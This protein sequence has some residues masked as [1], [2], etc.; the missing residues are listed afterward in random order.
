MS[1]RSKPRC[2]Q[3][4]TRRTWAW[5]ASIAARYCTRGGGAA[6]LRER[7]GEGLDIAFLDRGPDLR[8]PGLEGAGGRAHR[9]PSRSRARRRSRR[10][11]RDAPPR[12][13]AR[14]LRAAWPPPTPQR[15]SPGASATSRGAR[16]MAPIAQAPGRGAHLARERARAA[17]PP[18]RD[19]PR[20]RRS[21]GRA[22]PR[23]RAPSASRS[24]PRSSRPSARRPRSERR[25]PA[26][27]LEPHQAAVAGRNPDRPA[28]VAGVRRRHQPGR[29]R[30]RRAAARAAARMCR[31]P[32]VAGAGRRP[33]APWSAAGPAP[34]CWCGRAR[35]A[36]RAAGAPRS[37]TPRAR[38]SRP[39]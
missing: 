39:S 29:H 23:C 2:H 3:P 17:A 6:Q 12:R 25:P 27:G 22:A 15:D 21:R 34:A 19:R 16:S 5:F 10:A 7:P 8:A 9:R 13:G 4:A 14:A 38:T 24:P 37:R 20:A 1:S 30:R 36:R 32:R 35:S 26:R 28:A 33:R 18:S 31:L 11:R